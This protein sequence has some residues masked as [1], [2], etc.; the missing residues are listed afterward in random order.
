MKE[1]YKKLDVA[2]LDAVSYLHSIIIAAR[3]RGALPGFSGSE[4]RKDGISAAGKL[5]M[6]APQRLAN[7][8][9]SNLDGPGIYLPNQNHDVETT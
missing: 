9:G 5:I 8:D 3:R 6:K 4:W 7:G 1:F 2:C